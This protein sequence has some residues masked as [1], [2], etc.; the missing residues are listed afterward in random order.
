[1]A[2]DDFEIG[3]WLDPAAWGRGLAFEGACA[4]RAEA[5]GRVGA[6]SLIALI[7]PG[8]GPSQRL[9]ARLGMAVECETVGRAR[10]SVLVYRVT[11]PRSVDRDRDG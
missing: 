4:V 7:Q 9:A 10:E 2:K 11:R 1:M 3:W 6:P 8:N 5:F